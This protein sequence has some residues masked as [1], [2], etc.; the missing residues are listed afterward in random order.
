MGSIKF[1]KTGLTLLIIILFAASCSPAFA[2][3]PI[4]NTTLATLTL[5]MP[6]APSQTTIPTLVLTRT[7]TII[8]TPL[9]AGLELPTF[10]VK[11]LTPFEELSSGDYAIIPAAIIGEQQGYDLYYLRLDGKKSGKLLSIT[12]SG[13]EENGYRNKTSQ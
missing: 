2:N 11:F 4:Q 7:P 8:P 1:T 10:Q 5:T 3:T 12:S 9:G 13:N 6:Q